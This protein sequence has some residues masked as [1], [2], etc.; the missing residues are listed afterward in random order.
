LSRH[1][2]RELDRGSPFIS[3]ERALLRRFIVILGIGLSVGWAAF[4]ILWYA[5]GYA[6]AAR[7][8]QGS[9]V[10]SV[11]VAF[12]LPL[13]MATFAAA[14]DVEVV[15]RLSPSMRIVVVSAFGI[16]L[17]GAVYGIV[18]DCLHQ[19]VAPIYL[20]RSGGHVTAALSTERELRAMV[21]T[22]AERP[23]KQSATTI[24]DARCI[25]YE[26]QVAHYAELTQP[27][28][29]IGGLLERG[30]AFGWLNMVTSTI[31]AILSACMVG[32]AFALM[33]LPSDLRPSQLARDRLLM[34]YSLLILFLPFRLVS[35]W[36][37]NHI[38]SEQWLPDVAVFILGGVMAAVSVTLVL[39][40]SSD[41][42]TSA[43]F[44]SIGIVVSGIVSGLAKFN[45]GLFGP[46]PV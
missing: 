19:R 2:D 40:T 20:N 9:L 39:I 21:D 43:I 24:N 23:C 36:Y 13:G 31:G 18:S 30:G 26:A 34:S 6:D 4:P 16:L 27:F 11:F 37:E 42:R 38:I 3:P 35:T 14:I 10:F 45:E 25:Y 17:A 22:S 15:T 7:W 46:D 32:Y 41:K 5:I 1:S 28:N 8:W 29:S 44:S 12:V 33:A